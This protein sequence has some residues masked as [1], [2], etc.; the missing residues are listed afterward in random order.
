M[1]LHST[2]LYMLYTTTNKLFNLEK[3]TESHWQMKVNII[4]G[5]FTLGHSGEAS[6]LLNSQTPQRLH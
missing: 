3:V 6:F 2:S 4:G 1:N 5:P